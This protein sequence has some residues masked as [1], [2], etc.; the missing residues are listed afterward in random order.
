MLNDLHGATASGTAEDQRACD[1]A[2]GI[3]VD[4]VGTGLVE[5]EEHCSRLWRICEGPSGDIDVQFSLSCFPSRE[6]F[7]EHGGCC[8]LV[9]RW[10]V[11]AGE[12]RH[13]GSGA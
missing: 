3:A 8:A 11:R 6:R 7:A 4:A 5:A 9:V 2:R 10:S 1:V 12:S 13:R